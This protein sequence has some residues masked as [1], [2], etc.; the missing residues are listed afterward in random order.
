MGGQSDVINIADHC[1]LLRERIAAATRAAGRPEG[2]VQLVAVTKT[3]TPELVRAAWAAGL[4]AFGENR[5]QELRRKV[6][7]L[8]DL[9]I[10]WHFI[11][12]LQTNKVRFVVPAATLIH[13][14]DRVELAEQIAARVP[15]ETTQSVLVQVNTTGE[16]T[17][18]G[19]PPE[20]LTQLLDEIARWPQLAVRGLMTIGPFTEDRDAVRRAFAALREAAQRERRIARP[21]ADLRELSMG[22]SG[23]YEIAIAEGATIIRV[24]T[25]IFGERPPAPDGAGRHAPSS[26]A[27]DV[28]PGPG[29]F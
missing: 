9:N 4:Q 10:S 29:A 3:V 14:L 16:D 24:G 20:R 11:G 25:A 8:H 2:A 27:A 18:S 23:D 28:R 5:A 6:E 12:H 15:P 26:I 22:M 19:V 21:N 1:R 7:A 13:S 17:K